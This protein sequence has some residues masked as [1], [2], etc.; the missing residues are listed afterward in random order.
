MGSPSTLNIRPR[1]SF[2]TGT[3][4]VSPGAVT[5]IP[6]AMPSLPASMMHRTMLSSKC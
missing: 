4:M 6:R 1:V 2:P 5:F 3:V